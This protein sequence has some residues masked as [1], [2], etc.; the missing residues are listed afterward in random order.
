MEEG[1]GIL[2]H[3]VARPRRPPRGGNEASKRRRYSSAQIRINA[4]LRTFESPPLSL[5]TRRHDDPK[6]LLG[7]LDMGGSEAVKCSLNACPPPS[8]GHHRRHGSS[9]SHNCHI[10]MSVTGSNNEDEVDEL[11]KRQHARDAREIAKESIVIYKVPR[12][13]MFAAV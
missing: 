5:V 6:R 2:I 13:A 7:R 10:E 1:E 12:M 8:R 9:T 3:I 4:V 11:S